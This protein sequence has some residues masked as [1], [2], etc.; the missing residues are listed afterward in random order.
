MKTIRIVV[1]AI[2]ALTLVGGVA[3]FAAAPDKPMADPT[4]YPCPSCRGT[5]YGW[6]CISEEWMKIGSYSNIGDINYFKPN[7]VWSHYAQCTGNCICAPAGHPDY[8]PNW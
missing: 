6:Y 2:L 1:L 7:C 3:V 8:C 4:G 5:Q